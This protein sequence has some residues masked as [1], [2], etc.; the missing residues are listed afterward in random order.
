MDFSLRSS[1]SDT[2]GKTSAGKL[3]II[4]MEWF[5]QR[6]VLLAEGENTGDEGDGNTNYVMSLALD[7]DALEKIALALAR[8]SREGKVRSNARSSPRRGGT[9]KP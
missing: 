5:K 1:R 4:E 9:V 8:P 2:T 6:L 3:K 7:Q